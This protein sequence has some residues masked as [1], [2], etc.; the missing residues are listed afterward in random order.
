MKQNDFISYLIS[1]NHINIEFIQS[2]AHVNNLLSKLNVRA[3]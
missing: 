3:I 2:I 1:R